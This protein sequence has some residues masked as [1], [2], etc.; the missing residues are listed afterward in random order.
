MNNFNLAENLILATHITGV[1]DVN[2]NTTLADD[3]FSLVSDWSKSIAQNGLQ[4]IVFHNN[5]SKETCAA[6]ESEHLGF[7]KIN[8]NTVYNPNVYRYLVYDHFLNTYKNRIKNIFLTDISDV[9]VLKNPFIQSLY[10]NNPTAIF[11]GDEPEVLENEWMQLH[12]KHLRTK[13]ADYVHFENKFKNE[14]LLNCGI[15]GGNI[16]VMQP[17]VKQLCT[18]HQN[19]NNDNTSAYTG[20]M[21]AFNYLV[22]TAYSNNVIHGK[23]VNTVFKQYAPDQLCWFKHK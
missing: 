14:T 16:E 9:I 6:N 19:F 3:D 2:R 13:I 22:R 23:P 7:V 8:Y 21:A 10:I 1:Y 4:G 17:F 20:D 5:F 12:A 11:C 15:I 18:I